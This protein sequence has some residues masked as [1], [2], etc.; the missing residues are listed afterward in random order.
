MSEE[1]VI[2]QVGNSLFGAGMDG[3][4]AA[5][6]AAVELTAAEIVKDMSAALNAASTSAAQSALLDNASLLAEHKVASQIAAEYLERAASATDP[7][8]SQLFQGIA[9]AFSGRASQVEAQL[10]QA[11]N[12]S[13]GVLASDAASAAVKLFGPGITQS[14]AAIPGVL[15]SIHKIDNA[16]EDGESAGATSE[17]IAEEISREVISA[18]TTTAAAFTAA[19]K[20]FLLAGRGVAGLIARAGTVGVLLSLAFEAGWQLGKFISAD[21]WFSANVV[22]LLDP[23]FS[24]LDKFIIDPVSNLYTAAQT[25]VAPRRDPLILDLD[26]DG[27]ETIAL[28][29]TNPILFDHN[30]DGIKTGTGWVKGDDGFLVLDRNGNGVIDD[31]RELFG[32]A[33]QIPDGAGGQRNAIDGFEALQAQDTNADGL[34]N[35]LDANFASLR[36]WQDLN[37]DGISQT[38]ELFTLAQKNIASIT[39]A[40]TENSTLLPN[41]NVIA[42]LGHY[43]KTDGTTATLGETAQLGDV[44]LRENTFYS[45]FTNPVTITPAAQALPDMRGSEIVREWREAA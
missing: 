30:A 5:T 22:P 27:L 4:A 15:L 13:G 29:T 3:A 36:I 44:D 17:Q 39:V 28:N 23:F 32:D 1:S 41:G 40:K 12:S 7:S 37:Q 38:N 14:L 43:T 18:G 19:A 8:K 42:D 9:S 10:I 6:G 16:I 24:F 25:W 33:T 31:G 21:E 34:V 2:A 35:N 20:D 45:A 11:A 26:A